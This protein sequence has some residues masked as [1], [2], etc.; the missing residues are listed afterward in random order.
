MQEVT[1]VPHAQLNCIRT[2]PNLHISQLKTG[3]VDAR[4]ARMNLFTRTRTCLHSSSAFSF[5]HS[6]TEASILFYGFSIK[7]EHPS[8]VI[9]ITER[10]ISSLCP[11]QTHSMALWVSIHN[12]VQLIIARQYSS[13][14][15]TKKHVSCDSSE[16]RWKTFN[17]NDF[18]KSM[19]GVVI[20]HPFSRGQ[21][22]PSTH[23]VKWVGTDPRN[24]GHTPP[25]AKA[26]K[27]TVL[28]IS[29]VKPSLFK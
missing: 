7:L 18:K 27:K 14:S 12:S 13:P 28:R 25:Q 29:V 5:L 24:S 11:N 26:S 4:T 17:A 3:G 6:D 22:H 2:N 10:Q 16:Q 20:L 15:N 19:P 9:I 8:F 1:T 23:R 21:H